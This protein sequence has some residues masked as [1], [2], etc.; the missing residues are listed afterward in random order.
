[1]QIEE[2]N[3]LIKLFDTYGKLL[4]SRQYEVMDKMLNLDIGESEL[5]ELGGESRQAIHDAITKAKKQL[6]IFEENCGIVTNQEK[7]KD[8]LKKT[9]ILLKNNE[10]DAAKNAIDD[11]IKKL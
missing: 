3:S 5:A 8:L 10:I 4:S 1:M 9:Q 11:I 7:C 2:R 6:V